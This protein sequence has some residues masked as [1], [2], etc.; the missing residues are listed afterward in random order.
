MVGAARVGEFQTPHGKV[1]TPVFMPVGTVGT[2][3]S[4]DT[5]DITH[6]DAQIILGNTYHLYL[7]PGTETL[8]KVGG[9]HTFMGWNKPILTD[10]G[11]FQVFSL[12]AASTAKNTRQRAAVSDEGVQF[13]SHIDGSTHFFTPERSIEIQRSI[14]A[15]IIMAFDEALSDAAPEEYAKKSLM[16]TSE[17]A[18][19][20]VAY[21]E[22]RERKSVYGSYQA[23]FG[24]IQGGLFPYLRAQAA[25]HIASLPFD[26][27]ALGGETIGYNM[28][29]TIAVM[30]QLADKLPT[31]KPRYAMGLGRDPQDI[32][33]AFWAGVDMCD[34]VGP[35]RLA[36]NGALYV[37][38]IHCSKGEKPQFVSPFPK[39]RLNIGKAEWKTD[40]SVIL[41]GCDCYT[42]QSGYT[43]A[44]LHH[45][46]STQELTYYRLASIHNVRVMLRIAETVRQLLLTNV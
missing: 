30:Q 19:R 43:R 14:G 20:C 4:L 23:L 11:G 8:E 38:D 39:A 33:D 41:P 32:I 28:P 7:R 17:W 22:T 15:D 27:I 5:A 37:G 24:I 29:A 16:R 21:W 31:D 44:Y 42:C 2:V 45:L 40:K 12:G 3:K 9:L 1:Q 25:E 36:R 18:E 10:S 35:T 34:C 46:Y 13:H 6:T 26:G